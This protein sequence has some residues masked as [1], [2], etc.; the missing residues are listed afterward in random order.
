MLKPPSY[1]KWQI[2]DLA[3]MALADSLQNGAFA[4]VVPHFKLLLVPGP[5][6]PVSWQLSFSLD[7]IV[8]E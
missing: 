6:T 1:D 2:Q 7:A 4:L 5:V 8:A 3:P